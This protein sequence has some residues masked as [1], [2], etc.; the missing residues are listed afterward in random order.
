MVSPH[1]N[2]NPDWGSVFL[3]LWVMTPFRGGQMTLS[4]AWPKKMQIFILWFVKIV[5]LELHS[6]IKSNLMV[7]GHHILK[8]YTKGSWY[9]KGWKPQL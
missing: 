8:S 3:N 6:I 2:R 9:Y 7:E 5:K 4:Q 1:S